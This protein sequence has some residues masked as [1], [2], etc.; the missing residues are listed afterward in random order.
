MTPDCRLRLGRTPIQV[1]EA[2]AYEDSKKHG[3]G[4]LKTKLNKLEQWWKYT[5]GDGPQKHWIC[6]YCDGRDGKSEE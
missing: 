3:S 5:V 4:G 2:F 1:M 6:Y